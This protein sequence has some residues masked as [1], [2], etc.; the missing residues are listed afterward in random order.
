[1]RA[2]AT[3]DYPPTPDIASAVARRLAANGRTVHHGGQRL[4]LAAAYGLA[5][6]LLVAAGVLASSSGAR[7]AV[8]DFLGLA[9]EGE[10][11]EV[12]PTPRPGA[13]TTPSPTPRPLQSFATPVARESLASRVGFEPA[14]PAGAEEP[15]GMYIVDYAGF[16]VPVLQYPEFD[17]WQVR[18]ESGQFFGKG[19]SFFDKEIFGGPGATLLSETEVNGQR[20]YWISNGSH[21]VRFVDANGSVVTGS[22]RTVD[23]HTLVWRSATDVN[24]RIET[25]LSLEQAVAIAETLP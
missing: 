12:L 19:L 18:L 20:A 5:A 3:I 4:A 11:I 25:D 13:T 8:A 21:I 10:Q 15:N 16:L 24:Y 6:V 22:E 17:L 23:R 14:R 2:A 9:V 7:E 1:M